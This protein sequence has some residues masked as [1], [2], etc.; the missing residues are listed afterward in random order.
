MAEKQ[1]IRQALNKIDIAGVI[2]EHNLK[3]GKGEN[4]E[5]INGSF[6]VKAGEFTEITVKVMVSKNNKQGK[7]RKSYDVLHKIFSGEYKTMAEVSEE[8]AVKVRL[9]GSEGFSPQFKEEFFKPEGVDDVIERVVVDLGFGNITV[10]NQMKSED[11]RATFDVEVFVESIQEEI[12]NDE[13]TGRVIIKGWCPV[14]GGTVIPLTIVAGV[15]KDEEGEYDFAEDVRSQIDPEMTVNFWGDI[16]FRS[17]VEKKTK[18]GSMGKAKIE[19]KRTYIHDL[20]AIGAEFVVGEDEY[21]IEDIKQARIERENKKQEAK[22]KAENKDG[23]PQKRSGIA[24]RRSVTRSSRPIRN[25]TSPQSYSYDSDD[26]DL[27]F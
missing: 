25:N 20:V 19:E 23:S 16:D 14:Y 5:Y 27:P 1:E 15:I 2:K 17:I 13:D 24:G 10:D 22:E 26:D 18:G 11:Y 8:E 21:D 4:G 12:K 3:T 9:W 7:I 6:V